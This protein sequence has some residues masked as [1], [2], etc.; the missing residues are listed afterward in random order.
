MRGFFFFLFMDVDVCAAVYLLNDLHHS[1][2]SYV[3]VS[4]GHY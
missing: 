3:S 4:V 1:L 2:R